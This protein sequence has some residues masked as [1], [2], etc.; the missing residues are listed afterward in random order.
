MQNEIEEMRRKKK[1]M[2]ENRRIANEK[3]KNR[4]LQVRDDDEIYFDQDNAH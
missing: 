2:E 4:K 1:V 3:E